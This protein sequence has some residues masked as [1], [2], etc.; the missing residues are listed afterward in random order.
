MGDMRGREREDNEETWGAWRGMACMAS[1][2]R[3]GVAVG[4][5]C[6]SNNQITSK[7]QWTHH[8]QTAS[9]Q[10]QNLILHHTCKAAQQNRHHHTRDVFFLRVNRPLPY[11]HESA[12]TNHTEL[13]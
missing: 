1:G 8:M 9:V 2:H 10:R 11:M 6:D 5:P 7:Q 13:T 3:A 4:P 12:V